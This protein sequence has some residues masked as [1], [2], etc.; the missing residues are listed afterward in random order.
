[1]VFSG[2]E[3]L[4]HETPP[5]CVGNPEKYASSARQFDFPASLTTA[6]QSVVLRNDKLQRSFGSAGVSQFFQ[7]P[8][9]AA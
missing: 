7:R 4:L 2:V 5:L 8:D 9:A 6:N 1:M 3:S